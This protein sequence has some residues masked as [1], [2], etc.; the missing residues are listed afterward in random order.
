M[1]RPTTRMT[2]SADAVDAQFVNDVRL[3][4]RLSGAVTSRELPSGDTVT[5]LRLVVGRPRSAR[6]T[7]RSPTTDTVD[8]A[9]WTA[10]VRQRAERLEPGSLVE[11]VGSLRRRFW[12]SPG[13]AVSRYEVEVRSL[14]RLSAAT[15]SADRADSR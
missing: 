5:V 7:A 12:R 10:R 13:G 15:R 11:I 6:R 2:S 8:C 3:V 1:A 14:R 9:V 4:G